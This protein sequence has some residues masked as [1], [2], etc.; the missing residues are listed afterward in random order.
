MMVLR[1]FVVCS[2]NFLLLAVQPLATAQLLDSP[3]KGGAA[4]SGGVV[5][6]QVSEKALA[7]PSGVKQTNWYTLPMPKI[8]MPKIEMPRFSMPSFGA[9]GGES[10]ADK[11]SMFAPLTAGAHK[12]SDGSKK[13]WEGA[14]DMFSFGR[15]HSD[16]KAPKP[17]SNKG[18][19][20]WERM[21]TPKEPEGPRTVAEWMAQPRLDH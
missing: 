7:E 3:S 8:T 14:K 15:G 9:S 21:F 4:K 5:T 13:A 18:P 6:A 20:L 1:I 11:P 17:A 10:S 19:S 16:Q 12:V 2:A